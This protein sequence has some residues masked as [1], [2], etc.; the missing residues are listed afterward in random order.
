M[1][2]V[3]YEE[4]CCKCGGVMYIITNW[5]PH[6]STRGEC[7]DCGYTYYTISD[8]MSLKRV[9]EM[10][11]EYGIQLLRSLKCIKNRLS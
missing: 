6:P 2:E 4:E 10:R 11:K 1:S 8:Q 5:R 9:N 3:S 7:L